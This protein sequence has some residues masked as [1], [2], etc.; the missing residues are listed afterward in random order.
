MTAAR[1]GIPHLENDT[2]LVVMRFD[3][4]R[5]P[6]KPRP[7]ATWMNYGVHPEDL[8]GYNLI[9]TDFVGPLE[10]MVARATGAP[11]VFSQGDVGSSEPINDAKL[12]MPN[13][14]VR[15]FAHQGYAQAERQARIMADVVIARLE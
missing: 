15:A 5:D 8:D 14:V 3:D 12:R 1:L 6:A 10:R 11:L 4:I 2:G 13:G 9:S 7:L